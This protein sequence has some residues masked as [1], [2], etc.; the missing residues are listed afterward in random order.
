VRNDGKVF[1]FPALREKIRTTGDRNRN[2]ENIQLEAL[3][4]SRQQCG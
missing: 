3:H 4:A 1:G 2:S